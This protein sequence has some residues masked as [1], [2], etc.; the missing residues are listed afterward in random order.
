MNTN[1]KKNKKF[2]IRYSEELNTQLQEICQKT[3]ETISDVFRRSVQNEYA[4]ISENGSKIIS[5]NEL[6]RDE[7]YDALVDLIKT[8]FANQKEVIENN[9]KKINKTTDEFIEKTEQK[10]NKIL[11][12]LYWANK[13]LSSLFYFTFRFLFEKYNVS[14]EERKKIGSENDIFAREHFQRMCVVIDEN[15]KDDINDLIKYLSER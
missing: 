8:K 1:T 4:K 15:A 3:G 7:K 14:K 5:T 13:T 2:E 12:L 9:F 6:I 11:G 10:N